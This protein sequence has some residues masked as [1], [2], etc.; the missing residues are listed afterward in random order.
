M[1]ARRRSC[2]RSGQSKGIVGTMQHTQKQENRF[3]R[4]GKLVDFIN[5][6]IDQP[7]SVEQLAEN[8]CWS[9]WQLQRVFHHE[10]GLNLA[11]YVRELKLSLAAEKLLGSRN[12]VLDIGLDL[13]FSSEVSFSRAFK[14]MFACSPVAYR[15]RG[16]RLGLRTPLTLCS[17]IVESFNLEARL[18][19]IR[20]ESRSQFTVDCVSGL[21][22]GI[23][24]QQPNYQHEVPMIWSQFHQAVNLEPVP[25]LNL[26]A[27]NADTELVGV[28]GVGSA[29]DNVD[30]IPYW[31]GSTAD[32]A[33]SNLK[34][35][36]VPAQEYAVIPVV[37][38][39][40]QLD[41]VL[42]WLLSCWLPQSNYCGIDGY[43]LEIYPANYN[44]QDPESQ[45]EYW[46]PIKAIA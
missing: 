17:S 44:S 14:N 15:K 32:L 38:P 10:T 37:G 35:L 41:K 30:A 4:I 40:N 45:M 18:L 42:I 21:I 34:K 28:I 20:I 8:S 6:N 24:S 29:N 26:T 31:A 39:I 7:L 46:L 1:L 43:E 19:Q 13:G 22:S 16:Q 3:T 27:V 25:A 11:Q 2:C 23:F 36:T 33:S 5:E 12:K 9:R